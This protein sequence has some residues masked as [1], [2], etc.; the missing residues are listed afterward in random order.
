MS[1]VS[2][3]VKKLLMT[4]KA[5]RHPRGLVSVSKMTPS[6]VVEVHVPF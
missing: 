4:M 1:W 5:P 3:D 6:G 2:V